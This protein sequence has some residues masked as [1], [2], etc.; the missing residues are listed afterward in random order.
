M[1]VGYTAAS[2]NV[3]S[4]FA[5]LMK[6]FPEI[7]KVFY[8][9]FKQLPQIFPNFLIVESSTKKTETENTIG[10]RGIWSSKNEAAEYTFGDLAQGTEVAYTHTTYTD[11]FDLSEEL[12]E[13]NQWKTIMRSAREMAR[14]GYACAEDLATDVLNNAFSSGTGADGSYLC[15]TDHNLIN[16]GSTGSNAL[17]TVLSAQG[18]E[19]AYVLADN[20]VNEAGVII[21]TNFTTL[22]VPPA[23]RRTAEELKGS[24]KTPENNNNAINVYK[25]EITKIVVDPY[26]TSSTAW[27]L[28]DES[29]QARGKFFWRVKP[30]FFNDRDVYSGNY[31]MKARE[32]FSYG[33]TDWQGVIGSTGA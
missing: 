15:V 11:A 22:V 8:D 32:R 18:L 33:H 6:N 24:D 29:S 13:D 28:V 16:S 26:L 14:G 10:P 25:N 30:Q 31:L 7:R 20:I 2:A 5:T 12:M 21:P 23:L 17:T 9:E 1:A 4:S 19:D 27:F 3:R